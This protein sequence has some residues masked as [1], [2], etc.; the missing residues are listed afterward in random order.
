MFASLQVV[1][2]DWVEEMKADREERKA[3]RKATE[4]C[5]GKLRAKAE[6]A[7]AGLEEM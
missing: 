3:K 4:A 1:V 5:L 6:K 2:G 7:K